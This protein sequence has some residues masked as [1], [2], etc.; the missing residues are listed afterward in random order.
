MPRPK[1]EHDWTSTS[2]RLTKP[3][4][5]LLKWYA[6][7]KGQPINDFLWTPGLAA[8]LADARRL[9]ASADVTFGPLSEIDPEERIPRE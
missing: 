1:S 8:T 5:A 2:A 6:K 3:A 9:A 4:K 7:T